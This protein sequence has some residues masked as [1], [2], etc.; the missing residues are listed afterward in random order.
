MGGDPDL[1][2]AAISVSTLASAGAYAF[3]LILAG[4]S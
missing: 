4:A 1:A 2:S 3:W